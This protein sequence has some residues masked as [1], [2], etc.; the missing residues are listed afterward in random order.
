[1][2]AKLKVHIQ[3]QK[4]NPTLLF[5]HAFPLFAHMWKDQVRFFSE[6]FYCVAVDLPGFGES[7]IPSHPVTFEM[8]VDT[9]LNYLKEEK[10]ENAVW[11]GLS[12]GGYLALRLYERSPE[13]CRALIL[14]DTKAGA[15]N[16]EGKVKRWG[17]IQMLQTDRAAFA[18][19][20][21]K[22]LIG[23]SSQD[24]ADLKTR[25]DKL[26]SKTSSEGIAAGL[27]ALATRTDS[28]DQLSQITVPTLI[29]V[30]EEDKVTP[31]SESEKMAKAIAGSHLKVISKAGHL[32]NLENPV[33]FN[34][35]IAAFLNSMKSDV[36]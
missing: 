9:V 24:N 26:I 16:N 33:Q 10:I 13:L 27:V 7:P 19:A 5:L 2:E 34:E 32:S 30:G 21:W 29:L 8:Y 1:M 6:N 22:A 17:A 31:V 4:Q 25:F 18:N 15:D 14:C 35:H 20:Q 3:G 11:C 36:I 28:T 23:E 12:M